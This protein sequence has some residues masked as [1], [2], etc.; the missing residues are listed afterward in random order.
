MGNLS[1]KGYAN[2][3]SVF[4]FKLPNGKVEVYSSN[5][6]R[7]EDVK[8]KLR[9]PEGT[10]LIN[11]TTFK[12]TDGKHKGDVYL[13]FIWT[14]NGSIPSGKGATEYLLKKGAITEAQATAILN[15]QTA[16]L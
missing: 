11:A 10:K 8:A 3:A 15:A 16:T 5:A 1:G 4:T 13:D 12:C 6:C 7:E 2:R 14:A 9:L